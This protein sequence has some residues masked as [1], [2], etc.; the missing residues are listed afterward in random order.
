MIAFQ[1]AIKIGIP[2]PFFGTENKNLCPNG[3]KKFTHRHPRLSL[4]TS[5]AIFGARATFFTPANVTKIFGICE[6]L[7]AQLRLPPHHLS[8]DACRSVV[9]QAVRNVT[10][11]GCRLQRCYSYI[12]LHW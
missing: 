6:L 3:F 11:T 12:E 2:Q 8:D 1:Q 9:Q 4:R 7:L 10:Q 5:H